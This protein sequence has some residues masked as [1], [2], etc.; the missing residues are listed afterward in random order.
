MQHKEYTLNFFE[1]CLDNR[2]Q[3][4]M[5]AD[6][7]IE[8]IGSLF[9]KFDNNIK[10]KLAPFIQFPHKCMYDTHS[11]LSILNDIGFNAIP[12]SPFESKIDDIKNIELQNR[13]VDAVIIEGE[14]V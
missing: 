13:T 12:K 8:N 6:Q 5:K 1:I 9:E 10:N 7:F 3:H 2:A 11:L 4:K 14:K